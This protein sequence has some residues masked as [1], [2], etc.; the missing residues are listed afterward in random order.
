M[1]EGR[2]HFWRRTGQEDT[3]KVYGRGTNSPTRELVLS[4]P[5]VVPLYLPRVRDLSPCHVGRTR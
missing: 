1:L 4:E 3:R 2:G 5:L